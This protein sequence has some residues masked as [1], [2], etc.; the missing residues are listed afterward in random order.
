LYWLTSTL[1]GIGQQMLMN[2]SRKPAAA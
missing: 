2:R 1:L